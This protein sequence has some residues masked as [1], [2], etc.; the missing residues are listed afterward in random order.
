M[1]FGGLV[2]A[3]LAARLVG[4]VPMKKMFIAIGILVILTSS[5][6]LWKVIAQL[7]NG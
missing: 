2:A 1:I 3:P 6:T 4:K 7:L 5:M